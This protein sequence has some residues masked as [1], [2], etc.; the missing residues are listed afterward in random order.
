MAEIHDTLIAPAISPRACRPEAREG[1]GGTNA[2]KITELPRREPVAHPARIL[3]EGRKRRQWACIV[4]QP[5]G[6]EEAY[7]CKTEAD[8]K[9]LVGIMLCKF[10]KDRDL[11][12][13]LAREPFKSLLDA[14]FMLDVET[15]RA[16]ARYILAHE[17]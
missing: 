14:M 3:F 6:E 7:P 12:R 15:R 4:V 10:E 17:E 11:K 13:G 2:A 5:N 9:W 8:A 16:L 1:D